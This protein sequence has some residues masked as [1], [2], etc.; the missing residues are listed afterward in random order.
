MAVKPARVIR[1]TTG[2]NVVW[3]NNKFRG[4]L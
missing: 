1:R 3:A 4:G 2:S